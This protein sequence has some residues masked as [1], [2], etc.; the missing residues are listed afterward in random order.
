MANIDGLELKTEQTKDGESKTAESAAKD[1]ITFPNLK[2][3]LDN[4][5]KIMYGVTIALFLGFIAMGYAYIQFFSSALSD[6]RNVVKEYNSE[7]YQ[8]LDSRVKQL[9]QTHQAS[10]SAK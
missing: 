1:N 9:E 5:Q 2:S 3:N 8:L 10:C 7:K 4:L 6:Y